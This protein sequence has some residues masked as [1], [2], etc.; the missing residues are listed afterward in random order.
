MN[1]RAHTIS[2]LQAVLLLLA[3]AGLLTLAAAP[4]PAPTARLDMPKSSFVYPIRPSEGR[5]P[6]FP[7]S[8]RPYQD[9]PEAPKVGPSLTDVSLKSIMGTPPHVF[10]II[11]NHT[12]ES[13]GEG[14]I[15][16]KDG[17]RMHIRCV[18]INPKAGTATIES[19]GASEVLHLSGAP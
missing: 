8:S 1:L 13:G 9:N 2:R 15:I 19:G 18:V 17:R 6:F 5:D 11:N 14:D 16:A 10:A 3:S 4:A 12:F 7:S